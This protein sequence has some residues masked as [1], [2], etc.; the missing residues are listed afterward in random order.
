MA[1]NLP[2]DMQGCQCVYLKAGGIESLTYAQRGTDERLA[3]WPAAF[4]VTRSG[5]QRGRLLVADCKLMKAVFRRAA[6]V[7]Y[8]QRRR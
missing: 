2:L 5:P 6:C 3:W 1:A 4:G 8:C 7:P